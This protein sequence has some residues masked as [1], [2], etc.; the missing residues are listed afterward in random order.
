MDIYPGY[1][2][3]KVQ[4]KSIES[5]NEIFIEIQ[6]HTY[7]NMEYFG[8]TQFLVQKD[9]IQIRGANFARL[10]V[11]HQAHQVGHN[12]HSWKLPDDLETFQFPLNFHNFI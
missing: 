6:K 8:Q 5:E 12:A 10:N 4:N 11:P 9:P 1:I 2:S 3:I 7:L